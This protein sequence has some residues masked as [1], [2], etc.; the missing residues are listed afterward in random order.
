[1]ASDK[2]QLP[3]QSQYDILLECYQRGRYDDAEKLAISLTEQFPYDQ[4]SWKVLGAVL[5][6]TGRVSESLF[7]SQK[8]VGI[9]PQDVEAHSNLG[10]T[11]KELGRLDEAEASYTQAIALN[12]N[13]SIA[14]NSLGN[15]LKELGRLDEAEASYTQAIA[16]NP[17]YAE[18]HN[19]LGNTLKEL[20]RLDEAEASYTQAIALNPDYAEAHSNL[21]TTLKELGRLDEAEASYTQA[22]VLKPDYAEAHNNLG[23]TLKELDKLEQAEASY[24]K[25][26]ELK[27]NFA[28]A[29]SNLGNTLKELD[30]LEQ[31]EASYIKAI[32]LKPNY[33]EAYY[34]LGALY[35]NMGRNLKELGKISEAVK[36][37]KKSLKIHPED[38]MGVS[39][40]LARLGYKDMPD[41]TPL[42]YMQDYYK[43]KSK[44][45]ELGMFNKYYGH[46]LIKNALKK[47]HNQHE[48]VDF[49]DLGC[50]AGNLAEFLRPYARTLVGVD[51]SPDM[52][53]VAKKNELY[54][55]LHKKDL[56][57]FLGEI[58]ICYDVVVAAAVMVHFSDLEDIFS[59][60]W[61][62]LKV[63]GKFIFS[64]FEGTQKD[65][66]L[67]S[68]LFYAHSEDYVTTL[69]NRLNFKIIYRQ[70][71]IH[72]YHKEIPIS[73]LVYTLEKG[74]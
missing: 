27:P 23:N 8:A 10:N 6:K 14:H 43:K 40:E 11:L 39:L 33:A 36:Y 34:N 60:V 65:I 50:G 1:M 53:Q 20:G 48:K 69:A 7:A 59:L 63:N 22:I 51:L 9:N 18:A 17:D 74:K 26:I 25:A 61:D 21:G 72:E 4:F 42:N 70:Q 71:G 68:S 55:S 44:Q 47:T 29:Y 15:T 46:L 12:P 57:K 38:S 54:D 58:T 41:K 67:N 30:K 73:A 37:F 32:E 16:L 2:E 64:I 24:S 52:L 62:R 19:S 28:M 5:K 3:S 45:Y 13:F 56:V 31:A 35:I 49:L 66:E